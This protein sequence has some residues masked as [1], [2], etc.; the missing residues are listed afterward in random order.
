MLPLA[1]MGLGTS[2][3]HPAE[4]THSPL[5]QEIMLYSPQSRAYEDLWDF[6]HRQL[7]GENPNC[8]MWDV[9]HKSDWA[10]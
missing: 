8:Q 2:R 5:G 3:H 10:D 4:L 9:A 1:N 6:T 7:K